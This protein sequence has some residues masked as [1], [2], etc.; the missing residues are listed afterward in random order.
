MV[1]VE[2][3]FVVYAG[4]GFLLVLSVFL[5]WHSLRLLRSRQTSVHVTAGI[6]LAMAALGDLWCFKLLA[7]DGFHKLR[8]EGQSSLTVGYGPPFGQRT[9]GVEEIKKIV[10]RINYRRSGNLLSYQAKIL[11]LD[12]TSVE[13]IIISLKRIH[14]V[15]L[16]LEKLPLVEVVRTKDEFTLRPSKQGTQKSE[17]GVPPKSD[18]AG[19]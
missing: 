19:G 5:G 9:F 11:F 2:N 17:Q 12:G 1:Y 3:P 8:V 4:L 14:E 16:E 13:S 18:H 6:V 15:E 7:F 10:F